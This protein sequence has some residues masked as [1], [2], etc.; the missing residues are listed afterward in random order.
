MRIR[1]IRVRFYFLKMRIFLTLTIARLARQDFGP[2]VFKWET[3][4]GPDVFKW[5]TK[6]YCF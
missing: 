2:D 1:I 5:E 3:N 6:A 4:F